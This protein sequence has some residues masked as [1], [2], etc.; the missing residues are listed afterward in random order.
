M[1]IVPLGVVA[2]GSDAAGTIEIAAAARSWERLPVPVQITWFPARPY[3]QLLAEPAPARCSHP[4]DRFH[5]HSPARSWTCSALADPGSRPLPLAAGGSSMHT[6]SPSCRAGSASPSAPTSASVCPA[7]PASQGRPGRRSRAPCTGESRR[8]RRCDCN[9]S[10]RNSATSPSPGRR[11]LTPASLDTGAARRR[12]VTPGWTVRLALPEDASAVANTLASRPV[13][14]DHPGRSHEV[15]AQPMV[16]P[17]TAWSDRTYG[18]LSSTMPSSTITAPAATATSTS[19]ATSPN[20]S[21]SGTTD[22]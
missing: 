20:H 18:G 11:P 17:S 16:L 1:A 8:R 2:R 4:T 13:E 15:R 3:P 12:P 7:R 6:R 9:S 21:T 14:R 19:T 10:W 5:S 22:R